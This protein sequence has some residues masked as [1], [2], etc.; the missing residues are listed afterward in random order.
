[1][2]GKASVLWFPCG[3]SVLGL[4]HITP[5]TPSDGRSIMLLLPSDFNSNFVDLVQGCIWPGFMV[6][7]AMVHSS[8]P[9]PT[10]THQGPTM[11]AKG[12]ILSTQA[13]QLEILLFP[14]PWST[15][16]ILDV[17][18]SPLLV[19]SLPIPP[20]V[21]SSLLSCW[22]RPGAALIRSLSPGNRKVNCHSLCVP[23][24]EETNFSSVATKCCL[25]ALAGGRGKANR[26]GREG[27]TSGQD[28][29]W[30]LSIAVSCLV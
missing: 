3:R 11:Q 2:Q 20:C 15:H 30:T 19:S 12:S 9:T 1:M 21:C 26:R 28:C 24:R 27:W 8:H 29:A 10:C 25:L 17:G 4:Q 13:V 16:S 22:H 7:L 5:R 23:L 6:H 14:C 18:Q